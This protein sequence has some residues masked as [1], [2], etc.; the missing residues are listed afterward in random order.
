MP[1]LGLGLEQPVACNSNLAS[2]G[3]PGNWACGG[4]RAG[5]YSKRISRGVSG[6][7]YGRPDGASSLECESDA[8]P[9]LPI[10][11]S[12][13]RSPQTPRVWIRISGL[14]RLTRSILT[15]QRQLSH[16]VN[17]ELG[18]IGR[19]ITHEYQPVELNPVPYMMTLGGQQFKQAYANLVLQYCGGLKGLGGGGCGGRSDRCCLGHAAAFLRARA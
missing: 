1:L 19:R 4:S 3:S 7:F 16:R 6:L 11:G 2:A 14:A 13:T 18:Y 12:T 17:L 10:L 15:I 5:T 8:C 9:S